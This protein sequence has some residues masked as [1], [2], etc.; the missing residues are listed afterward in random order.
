MM[1]EVYSALRAVSNGDRK[2]TAVAASEAAIPV[3]RTMASSSAND[4]TGR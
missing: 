4:T 2:A 1:M 3:M